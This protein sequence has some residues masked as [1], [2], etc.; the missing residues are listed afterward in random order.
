[1]FNNDGCDAALFRRLHRFSHGAPWVWIQREKAV[2]KDLTVE[3]ILPP[4][5]RRFIA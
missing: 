4:A 5:P 3:R 1:V 2:A